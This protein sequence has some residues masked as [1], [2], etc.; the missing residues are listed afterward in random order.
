[1]DVLNIATSEFILNGPHNNL[2]FDCCFDPFFKEKSAAN[3]AFNI[4]CKG[5][6]AE[7]RSLS[8]V[9]DEPWSFNALGEQFEI[10]R[11]NRTGRA[12]WRIRTSSSFC[13]ADIDWDEMLFMDYYQSYEKAWKSGLGMTV[14]MLGLLNKNGLL[15]HGAAVELD[16]Q[17]AMF[18]GA[19]G[20]GKSTIS[21]LLHEAGA[22]VLT[23]ERPAIHGNAINDVG[24]PSRF[25]VYGTPWPSSAGFYANAKAGLKKIYFLE[26]GT[27][28]TI[29]PLSLYDAL[30]K[31]LDVAL[32]PWQIPELFDPCLKTVETLLANVPAA[33]LSF[34]PDEEVVDVIRKDLAADREI[35]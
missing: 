12:I 5:S 19:C 15:F 13:S 23:D 33:V 14:V 28:N 2:K 35:L 10:V 27:E 1:M 21:K 4:F 9:E 32:V 17:G 16:E 18:V 34:K 20:R 3:A 24:R 31:L 30:S 6:S 29:K 8:I 22:L 11:R 25:D 26:H 7:I